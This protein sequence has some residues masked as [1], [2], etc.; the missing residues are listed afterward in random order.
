MSIATLAVCCGSVAKALRP[1]ASDPQ[2][3]ELNRRLRFSGCVAPVAGLRPFEGDISPRS[4][5]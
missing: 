4:L 5:S 2:H 1:Q 3:E